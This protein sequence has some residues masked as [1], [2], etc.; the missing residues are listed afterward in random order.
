MQCR[1]IY[2]MLP[3]Y[4]HYILFLY[5]LLCDI[6]TYCS[7]IPLQYVLYTASLCYIFFLYILNSLQTV[8]VYTTDYIHNLPHIIYNILCTVDF[9][10]TVYISYCSCVYYILHAAHVVCYILCTAYLL[11]LLHI[12]LIWSHFFLC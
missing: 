2:H 11:K 6:M 12:V 8:N 3:L 7:Y 1:C 9:F 4:I 5:V 10:S